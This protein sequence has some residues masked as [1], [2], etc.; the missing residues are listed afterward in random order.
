MPGPGVTAAG[1]I[2]V[3]GRA[4]R[5]R[6]AAALVLI[7]ALAV[8]TTGCGSHHHATPQA[9]QLERTDLVDVCQALSAAA[10]SANREVAATK[11]AWPLIAHGLPSDIRALARAKIELAIARAQE[12]KLPTLFAEREAA[13]ITG[14]GSALASLFR[15]F[16]TL[17]RRA[18][19]LIGAAIQQIEHG[20]PLAARF[21]RAN[22][23]L[24]IESVYD[25][26]FEL[27]QIG[28]KLLQDYK[29][30]GGRQAFGETLAQAQVNSLAQTYSESSDR[31]RPH[32]GVKLGS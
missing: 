2:C 10:A 16:S 24:Y 28:S 25:A 4:T 12:L 30:Q 1:G 22:V 5:L 27:A 11:A 21:A 23:A 26:H 29:K 19:K 13:S 15:D 7:A 9:E 6:G 32:T 3:S 8:G 31:L 17:N 20:S 18:W 14:P